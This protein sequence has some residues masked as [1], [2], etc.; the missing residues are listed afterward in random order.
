MPQFQHGKGQGGGR[1]AAKPEKLEKAS[2]PSSPP[3]KGGSKKGS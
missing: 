2:K 3:P 1:P